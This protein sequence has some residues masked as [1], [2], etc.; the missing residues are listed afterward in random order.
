MVLKPERIERIT[1]LAEWINKTPD[2]LRADSLAEFSHRNGVSY[3]TVKKDAVEL[4]YA[5]MRAPGMY[6]MRF[7]P[8]SHRK[9]VAGISEELGKKISKESAVKASGVFLSHVPELDVEELNRVYP[10]KDAETLALQKKIMGMVKAI[11]EH[12]MSAGVH[13]VRAFSSSWAEAGKKIH[14]EISK[15]VE[16]VPK[17]HLDEVVKNI[18]L[19]N[20]LKVQAQLQYELFRSVQ[21][22]AL[23][24]EIS[25]KSMPVSYKRF[26]DLRSPGKEMTPEGM[27][28]RMVS[29]YKEVRRH[30]RPGHER[31]LPKNLKEAMKEMRRAPSWDSY[32]RMLAKFGGRFETADKLY[33]EAKKIEREKIEPFVRLRKTRK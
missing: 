6:D 28:K 25:R 7:V 23:R 10:A 24:K 1:R 8:R 15:A 3:E 13:P 11:A 16:E 9:S 29:D 22:S 4:A 31:K 2:A 33:A 19:S 32:G 20:F 14:H 26:V 17:E 21:S 5:C 18:W 12:K 30:S 27:W